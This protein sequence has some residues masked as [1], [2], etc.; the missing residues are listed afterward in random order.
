VLAETGAEKVVPVRVERS[1]AEALSSELSARYAR[2]RASEIVQPGGRRFV[3]DDTPYSLTHNSTQMLAE[4]LT[5]LGCRVT[6]SSYTAEFS[7]SSPSP[8]APA[9]PP[10]P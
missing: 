6:G 5:A 4:W 7:V 3:R 2:R 8:R 9:A 1:R 10:R